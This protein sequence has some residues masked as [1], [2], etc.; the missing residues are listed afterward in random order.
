MISAHTSPFLHQLCTLTPNLGD[1]GLALRLCL[2]FGFFA[3]LRQS[4]LTPPSAAQFN[5]SRHTCRGDVFFVPPGLNILLP[6]AAYHLLLAASPTMS[7]DQPYLTYLPQGRRTMVTVPIL[8]RALAGLLHDLGYNASLFSLHSRSLHSGGEGGGTAATGR[9]W[10]RLTLNVRDCG[11]AM[12]SGSTSRHPAP[13]LHPSQRDSPVPSTPLPPAHPPPPPPPPPSHSSS[14]CCH[15]QL[16][17][18]CSSHHHSRHPH[19]LCGS[20]ALSGFSNLAL[21]GCNESW[22]RFVGPQLTIMVNLG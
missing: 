17:I 11:P 4:N 7:P 13:P 8:S 22:P 5:P 9:A 1:L 15:R 19:V 18:C 6:V 16:A 20:H 12:P 14:T 2:T 10:T 3:M 21:L